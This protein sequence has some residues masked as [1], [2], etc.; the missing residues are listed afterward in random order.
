[1]ANGRIHRSGTRG[2]RREQRTV[3]RA[4][5]THG[6][7][8]IG[9]NQRGRRGTSKEGNTVLPR[10][11]VSKHDK[12]SPNGTANRAA[13]HTKSLGQPRSGLAHHT[14]TP[15]AMKDLL[16]NSGSRYR[17]PFII[18]QRPAATISALEAWG[19]WTSVN[20][21]LIVP[22]NVRVLLPFW[23]HR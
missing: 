15:A 12:Q 19:C 21:R 23:A 14:S 8:E 5:F 3:N 2:L 10:Q 13:A 6:E 1:M 22:S 20:P 18:W 7:M 9:K 11:A 17:T 16:V 4:I